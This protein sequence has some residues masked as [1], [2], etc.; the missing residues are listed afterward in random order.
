M[1]YL[2]LIMLPVVIPLQLIVDL[3]TV[4]ADLIQWLCVAHA[5]LI[6]LL[7][8]LLVVCLASSLRVLNSTDRFTLLN[9]QPLIV[10]PNTM[11]G[12]FKLLSLAGILRLL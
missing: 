9:T 6:L 8:V 7:T 11:S 4:L 2:V 12:T 5:Y 1:A 10:Q 3:M